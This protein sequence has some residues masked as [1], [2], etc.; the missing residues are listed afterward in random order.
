MRIVQAKVTL[1]RENRM[2][3][4]RDTPWH[5]WRFTLGGSWLILFLGGAAWMALSDSRSPFVYR[6]AGA[7]FFAAIAIV[8]GLLEW[9]DRRPL[10]IS[11][12]DG[13]TGREHDPRMEADAP[14]PTE[15]EGRETG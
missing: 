12:R 11:R 8:F 7:A 5:K 14:T 3:K 2:E 13:D 10:R 6:I 4:R 9:R 1:H 15:G